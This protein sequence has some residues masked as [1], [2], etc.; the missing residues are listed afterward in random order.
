M[1]IK[2]EGVL[3]DKTNIVEQILDMR[4]INK[5]WL[6]AGEQHLLDGSLMRNFQQGWDL[7]KKHQENRAVILI[8]ND[9]DGMT[10]AATMYQW[11]K[12]VYPK[13]QVS[14]VIG[15]GKTHGIIETI[16][17]STEEYDLLII[18]D[19]SSSE[20]DKHQSLAERG[21]D[22]LILDHHTITEIDNPY[23]VVIN[24]HHPE[25]LYPNKDLSGVGVVYKF[26]SAIDSFLGVDNHSQFLDLVATGIVADVMSIAGLENKAIVNLGVKNIVN[27]YIKAYLKADG[28][29][30]DKPFTPMVISFYLAP[31]IN[32]LIRMGEIDEKINLF[33]A[34]VGE[35]DAEYVVANIISLKGK[36]DR[37]KEPIVTRIVLN[38]QKQGKENNKLIIAEV[39]KNTPRALTGVIAGQ[40]AGLYQKPVLLGRIDEDGN[41]TGSARSLQKSSVENLKDY[42]EEYGKF[43]FA[44]GHQSAFGFSL[45][46]NLLSDLEQHMEKVLPKTEKF[47]SI[48]LMEGSKA[49][50]ITELSL[51]DEHYGPGFEEIL[52]YDEIYITPGAAQIIGKNNN[53]LRIQTNPV[54]YMAFR[55]KDE[56]P[57]A[58]KVMRLVGTP[59][60]ND[61][62]GMLTPQIFLKDWEMEELSL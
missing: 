15:E 20:K 29:I 11:L 38:L 25:C 42:C 1:N 28:R 40:L 23:A 2:V 39:P 53:T 35:L 10:S 32:A 45:P 21:K 34:M 6:T 55:F 54:T 3:N 22:I 7:L 27:P 41:F 8:D 57:E 58:E 30:K 33:K 51:L 43:H 47:H 9:T 46:G 31:Q 59:N 60:L 44:A 52:I 50:I 12:L 36:Q 49:E 24:P 13:M 62:N 16:L 18:P 26:I 5:E 4:G 14:Y 61:F 56:L 17:P 37:K 19:A 48:V